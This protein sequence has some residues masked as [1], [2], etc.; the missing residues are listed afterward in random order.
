MPVCQAGLGARGDNHGD[1]LGLIPFGRVFHV[2]P[3]RPLPRVTGKAGGPNAAASGHRCRTLV[4]GSRLPQPVPLP[5]KDQ[6][7]P[8]IPTGF[9]RRAVRLSHVR[10]QEAA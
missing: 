5:R 8:R 2:R 1:R 7:Q 3:P 6:G 9:W 10:K 4:E